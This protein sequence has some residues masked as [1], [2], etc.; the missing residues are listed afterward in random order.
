ME[1]L[2]AV[3]NATRTTLSDVLRRWRRGMARACRW[4]HDGAVIPGR[5][6][7]LSPVIVLLVLPLCLMPW[8]A[9]AAISLV[10]Q[11]P[12]IDSGSAQTSVTATFPL[13]M[14]AGN[15]LVATLRV[16]AGSVPSSVTGGG[17]TLTLAKSQPRGSWT[18]N[19]YY[20][21]ISTGG[22]KTVTLTGPSDRY[23]LAVSEWSG[24]SGTLDATG[25]QAGTSGSVPGPA[26][27]GD[28]I[29]T[30]ASD[31]VVSVNSIDCYNV[32]PSAGPTNSFL[33]LNLLASP[34]PLFQAYRIV[35]STGT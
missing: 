5:K 7:G 26:Y 18:V 6:R 3:M 15:V 24:L 33:A 19:I 27:S 21:T 22:T 29:T 2:K 1:S 8:P 13:N 14:T 11:T 4:R 17:T 25:G 10:Q 28:V 20:G 16:G 23:D 34:R 32:L 30:N 35:S 31:L 9:S 12:V